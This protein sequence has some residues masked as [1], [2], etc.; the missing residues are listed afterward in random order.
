METKIL[1]NKIQCNICKQIIESKSRNDFKFCDCG[2]VA[3]DG[4]LDYLRRIGTNYTE[5]SENIPK[6]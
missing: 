2:A 1:T 3:I 5:L 6:K 4:G